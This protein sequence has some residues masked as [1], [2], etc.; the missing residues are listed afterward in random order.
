MSPPTSSYFAVQAIP[1][2][3]RGV[4]AS[5]RIP[6][7]TVILDSKAPAAH[8]IFRQYRREVCAHCFEYDRGRTLPVRDSSTG[9]VF[10]DRRCQGVWLA[11]QG[12]LGGE[13]WEALH[14]FV[15]A[16]SKAVASLGST[17]LSIAN[18]EREEIDRAW[19][20]AEKQ[21]LR[22]T[23]TPQLPTGTPAAK[24]RFPS[25]AWAKHVDPDTLGYLLSGILCAHQTNDRW[26]DEVLCL[27]ADD[28][29]YKSMEELDAH[30]NSF[31]QLRAI[32][33]FD[34]LPSC[35]TTVCRALANAGSRNVFG[36]R[37]GSDG[38]EY[39]GYAMYPSASYFNHSCTP[40]IAKRRTGNV[41]EFCTVKEIEAGDEC[42]I[43]YLGGDEKDLTVWERRARLDEVWGFECMCGRCVREAESCPSQSLLSF[44][45]S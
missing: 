9:K 17:L 43:T 39:M 20:R 26:Q 34:L 40:G 3:G 8:V 23:T 11:G 35:T 13:A 2:A 28:E 7:G 4:V 15:Q 21:S 16:N 33:P 30:C 1:H 31:V 14:T 36:I 10:C 19:Y 44:G 45:S 22:A 24:A 6:A 27:A 12:E 37:S 42:C 38:E 32:L 5:R 29:P 18:P 41:W 25:Q